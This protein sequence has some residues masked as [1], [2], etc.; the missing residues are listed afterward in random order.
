M[1][2][3][4]HVMTNH[5][6]EMFQSAVVLDAHLRQP[7][8]SAVLPMDSSTL[9]NRH[10]VSFPWVGHEV[11]NHEVSSNDVIKN[12]IWVWS[13]GHGRVLFVIPYKGPRNLYK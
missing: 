13:S 1:K 8:Y 11:V 3:T 7:L 6:D 4:K 10:E 2:L 5:L 12:S 9:C